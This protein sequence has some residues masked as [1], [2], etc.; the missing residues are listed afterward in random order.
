MRGVLAQGERVY[1]IKVFMSFMSAKVTRCLRELKI[2]SFIM[3]YKNG[4]LALITPQGKLL[5]ANP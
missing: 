4:L 5:I 2:H 1:L 3:Y